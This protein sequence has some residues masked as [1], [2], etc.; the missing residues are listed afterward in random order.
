MKRMLKISIAFVMMLCAFKVDA[1]YQVYDIQMKVK[2]VKATTL[3]LPY[4]LNL[5]FSGTTFR[6]KVTETIKGYLVCYGPYNLADPALVYLKNLTT[7]E[8]FF[9]GSGLRQSWDVY[10]RL[11][12]QDKSVELK[13]NFWWT[14]SDNSYY[15]LY[16]AGDGKIKTASYRKVYSSGTKKVLI[17]DGLKGE[18]VGSKEIPSV[19]GVSMDGESK[20]GDTSS[21]AHGTW[22][23]KYNNRLSMALYRYS[24]VQSDAGYQVCNGDSTSTEVVDEDTSEVSTDEIRNILGL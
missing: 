1:A 10:D 23:I 3:S 15:D 5:Y 20:Q 8:A 6:T 7:G 19:Y 17:A 21:V 12:P 4:P 22:K 11:S 13:W 18:I 9:S 16:G 14:G 2:T 24:A